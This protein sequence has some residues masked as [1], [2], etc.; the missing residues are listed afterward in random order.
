MNIPNRYNDNCEI[1]RLLKI[2]IKQYPEQ[3]FGQILVNYVIPQNFNGD[4]FYPEGELF[5][6]EMKKH[7]IEN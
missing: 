4:L 5:I 6:N 3:R 7:A 2:L 1:L